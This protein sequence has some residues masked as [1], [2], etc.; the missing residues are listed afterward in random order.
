MAYSPAINCGYQSR[1]EGDHESHIKTHNKKET[2]KVLNFDK[3]EFNCNSIKTFRKHMNTRH[4]GSKEQN[5]CNTDLN[6]WPNCKKKF[7]TENILH[8]HFQKIHVG[9]ESDLYT[10]NMDKKNYYD[11][12]DDE[13]DSANVW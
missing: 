7:K 8:D 12:D 10:Q 11:S 4:L 3:C 9:K 2:E 6:I 13:R 5:E 1:S